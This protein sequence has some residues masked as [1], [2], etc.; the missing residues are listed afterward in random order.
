MDIFTNFDIKTKLVYTSFNRNCLVIRNDCGNQNFGIVVF[1][2]IFN[3]NFFCIVV[4][5]LI[6]KRAVR[7]DI[8]FHA[9][10]DVVCLPRNR[11]FRV[12]HHGHYIARHVAYGGCT[13]KRAVW[14]CR[15]IF[16]YFTVFVAILIG[17]KIFFLYKPPHVFINNKS[18]FG[19][20]NWNTQNTTAL[21]NKSRFSDQIWFNITPGVVVSGANNFLANRALVIR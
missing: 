13:V 10:K 3:L 4:Q 2:K 17:Y 5:G 19:V 11:S 21:F 7:L 6:A 18:S 16:W 8:L 20:S 1:L 12:R 15:K 14:V 9:F